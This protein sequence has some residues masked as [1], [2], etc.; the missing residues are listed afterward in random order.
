M[1][2][3]KSFEQVLSEIMEQDLVNEPDHYKGQN[4]MEVIN[5][6][7]NFAPCPEYAEGFFS[8]MSSSTSCDIHRKTDW[9]I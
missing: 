4:G 9:K 2:K 6:I 1:E 3:E 8:E 7:N 5:V